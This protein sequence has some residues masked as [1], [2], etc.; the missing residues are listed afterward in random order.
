MEV[1]RKILNPKKGK[2]RCDE[3]DAENRK[4]QNC[5]SYKGLPNKQKRE[6]EHFYQ[7]DNFDIEAN[8]FMPQGQGR[9]A[10]LTWLNSNG[11]DGLVQL[12]RERDRAARQVRR[13]PRTKGTEVVQLTLHEP[14]IK[15]VEKLHRVHRQAELTLR[16]GMAGVLA[17]NFSKFTGWNRTEASKLPSLQLA[18][19]SAAIKMRGELSGKSPYIPPL[20]PEP[21][22]W[23]DLIDPDIPDDDD[24]PQSPISEVG[25]WRDLPTGPP[26]QNTEREEQSPARHDHDSSLTPSST[27]TAE[28]EWEVQE[29]IMMRMTKI[30][31]AQVR[32][33]GPKA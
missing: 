23:F 22:G 25:G 29:A 9:E 6:T 26:Q 15:S 24:R 12:I 30:P 21:I 8:S 1:I 32:R 4:Y 27:S 2:K 18:H 7:H 10:T 14:S 17:Y 20:A 31:S 13:G 19:S 16:Y 3:E 33:R 28:D 5:P 11:S